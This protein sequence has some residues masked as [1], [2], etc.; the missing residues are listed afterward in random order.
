MIGK[1]QS[2]ASFKGVYIKCNG[3]THK[4]LQR[5]YKDF[6]KLSKPD[7]FLPMS[8]LMKTNFRATLRYGLERLN[9]SSLEDGRTRYL[10]VTPLYAEDSVTPDGY[11]LNILED[12]GKVIATGFDFRKGASVL[13]LKT[14]F[15]DL[16]DEYIE[17]VTSSDDVFSPEKHTL[18][19]VVNRFSRDNGPDNA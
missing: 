3:G 17:A 18:D 10:S 9:D 4:N 7:E 16:A 12:D 13:S 1:I 5:V 8:E 2:T 14:A 11:E 6:D 15:D 19:A